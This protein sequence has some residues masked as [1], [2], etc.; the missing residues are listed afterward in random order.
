MRRWLCGQIS[1]HTQRFPTVSHCKLHEWITFTS[2]VWNCGGLGSPVSYDSDSDILPGAPS[3]LFCFLILCRVQQLWTTAELR[4]KQQL[5]Q[6]SWLTDRY[7]NDMFMLLDFDKDKK[8][9]T[10][11]EV[12]CC[13]SGHDVR[14]SFL[15]GPDAAISCLRSCAT[16]GPLRLHKWRTMCCIFTYSSQVNSKTIVW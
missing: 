13:C 2:T 11:L 1:T 4:K 8:T 6:D 9:L 7:N 10:K 14:A 15:H 12:D 3:T 5:W 16:T